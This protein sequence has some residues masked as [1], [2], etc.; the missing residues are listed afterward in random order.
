MNKINNALH[1]ARK[2][3]N[4]ELGKKNIPEGPLSPL[5]L[6]LQ[7]VSDFYQFHLKSDEDALSYA[8]EQ[9]GISADIIQK[10]GIGFAPTGRRRLSRMANNPVWKKQFSGLFGSLDANQY[11]LAIL[12]TLEITGVI[13]VNEEGAYS[14]SFPDRLIVPIK[15]EEGQ[16]ISFGGRILPKY[17]EN[18]PN[19]PKYLNGADS[20]LFSK[21]S[22]LF[23]LDLIANCQKSEF[24]SIIVEE[25]YMDVIASHT[26]DITN[27][28]ATMG[29]A[30]NT[31]QILKLFEYTN[32]LVFC[33]D[34]D[35]AGVKAAKRAIINSLPAL[36]KSS[37]IEVVFLPSGEDPDSILRKLNEEFSK[38]EAGTLMKRALSGGIEVSDYLIGPF[39][40][41]EGL[42]WETQFERTH[43]LMMHCLQKLPPDC[44][45]RTKL[46][47]SIDIKVQ[48]RA[49]NNAQFGDEQAIELA[50][51]LNSN[52]NLNPS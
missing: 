41:S 15:N 21:S 24:E 32:K 31:G 17:L 6:S 4:G 40:D 51:K 38:E 9:R 8:M 36:H 43:A 45:T 26:Y 46:R 37:T 34:G 35:D 18:N 23:G 10:F 13:K 7:L 30:I 3:G 44:D 39:V 22:V 1:R 47:Q 14:D 20:P 48:E 25:G 33:F 50:E 49:A 19:R 52:C 11:E 28:V 27:C 2:S 16:T 12:N 29:T 42:D 5:Y